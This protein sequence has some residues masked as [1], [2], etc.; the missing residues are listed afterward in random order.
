[1]TVTML[2]EPQLKAFKEAAKPVHDKWIPQV[3]KDIYD[4]A[5]ADM[6]R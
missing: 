2:S 5:V 1:M 3:G 6:T 4:K